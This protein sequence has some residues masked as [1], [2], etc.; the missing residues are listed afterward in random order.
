MSEIAGRNF[1]IGVA[2]EKTTLRIVGSRQHAQYLQTSRSGTLDFPSCRTSLF[3]FPLPH[4]D[5]GCG[6]VVNRAEQFLDVVPRSESLAFDDLLH[7]LPERE[8]DPYTAG[9]FANLLLLE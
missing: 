7:G 1:C 3:P 9:D 2:A 4:D 6:Q 5:D 8:S